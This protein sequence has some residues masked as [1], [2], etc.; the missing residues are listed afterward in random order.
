MIA[1]R[2]AASKILT[3]DDHFGALVTPTEAQEN[4]PVNPGGF[5]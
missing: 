2:G 1:L 5:R 3:M 4:R